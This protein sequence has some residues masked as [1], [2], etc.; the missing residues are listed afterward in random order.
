MLGIYLHI[1]FCATKCPYCD[2]YSVPWRR[3]LAE[4]YT[5]ALLRELSRWAD[6]DP[7][8]ADT[9]Y[10]GGG[11]PSLLTPWQ[12]ASLIRLCRERF[13]LPEDGEITLEVNPRTV[14]EKTLREYR[15]AGVNRLSVGLQSPHPEE[16]S[17]L[18]RKHSPDQAAQ[19]ILQA[20]E[21]GFTDISADLILALPGQ[22][23]QTLEKTAAFL[24]ALPL[25][26]LSA[27]LLK[28][29]EGT[30]FGAAPPDHLPDSDQAAELYLAAVRLLD[31]IGFSQYEI[32]SFARPGFEGKHNANY[33]DCGEYLGVGAAAH[34]F[35]K[36]RRFFYPR[37]VEDFLHTAGTVSLPVDDGPGG[38]PEEYLILRLRLT[39]G[40][41]L[42]A[43]AS[44]FGEDA[45]QVL[46][47]KSD[48]LSRKIPHLFRFDGETLSLTPEGFL[49]SNSIFPYLTD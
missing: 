12:I 42:S 2:F 36:G 8:R 43:Y 47:Q 49:L 26:H 1:P 23:A 34:S 33:W 3:E 30:P 45:A 15:A 7:F 39:R 13:D 4:E 28:I 5:A 25:T 16:L 32:S 44:R 14:D 20:A 22:T 19:T 18:G 38:T 35:R 46:R 37:S 6:L 10:F 9:L 27:Y 11:T 29:E 41:S 48:S 31:G 17:I 21:A 24:S 40:L